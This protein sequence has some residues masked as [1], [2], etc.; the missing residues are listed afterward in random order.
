MESNHLK[1]L[2]VDGKIIS[3]E[4]PKNLCREPGLD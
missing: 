3:N 4:S 1:H 2:G